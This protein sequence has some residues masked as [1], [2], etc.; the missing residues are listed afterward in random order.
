MKVRIGSI[1][2]FASA[3]IFA[4]AA[5][6]SEGAAN[7]DAK[8]ASCHGKDGKGE[9]TIGKKMALRA[10]GSAEVQ[11]QTD[12]QLIDITAKGQKKMPAYEKKFSEQQ[13]KDLVTHIRTLATK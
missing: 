3:M 1:A 8:C 10:L 4:S 5:F 11:G 12:Q 9:T 13:I 7:Y 2:V 6:A